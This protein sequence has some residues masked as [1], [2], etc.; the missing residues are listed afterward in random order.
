MHPDQPFLEPII[1]EAI[2]AAQDQVDRE[3][4]ARQDSDDTAEALPEAEAIVPT[5]DGDAADDDNKT[6]AKTKRPN[7]RGRI[8]IPDWFERQ[9]I[10]IDVPEE[11]KIDPLTG[12][13]LPIIGHLDT[14]QV[15]V[16]PSRIIVTVHRRIKYGP[17]AQPDGSR[18]I[19]IP[20]LPPWLH[21]RWKAA[22][23]MVADIVVSKICDHLPL[24]RQSQRADRE[25]FS[26]PRSSSDGYFLKSAEQLA[27]LYDLYPDLLRARFLLKGDASS[28]AVLA[29]GLGRTHSGTIWTW[30]GSDQAIPDPDLVYFQYAP[31]LRGQTARDFIGDRQGYLQ[32]DAA[33]LFDQSCVLCGVHECGCW[34]HARRYFEKA[35]SSR[36]VEAALAVAEIR[37]FFQ[38]ERQAKDQSV[39]ARQ[40]L[41]EDQARPIIDQLYIYLK[42]WRI[43]VL[44]QEPLARAITYLTNQKTA[45][46][47]YLDDGRIDIDNSACEREFRYL[48]LGRHNWHFAGNARGAR[49]YAIHLTLVRNCQHADINPQAWYRDVLRRIVTHPSDRLAELLPH[50]WTASPISSPII[51]PAIYSSTRIITPTTGIARRR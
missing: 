34:A 35:L 22:P 13:P 14:E 26:M 23:G 33:N 9:I 19:I 36:P 1:Q 20:E 21:S 48:A 7:H 15:D 49:C 12:E 31:E 30:H 10:A 32:L 18:A 16:R 44:P 39:E 28:I 40:A 17:V 51:M 25:Q 27:P 38:L 11:D 3:I 24:Y 37:A 50:N 41:R 46:Y 43:D 5:S 8:R 47:R 42:R 4:A 2:A 45:L 29:P 6:P